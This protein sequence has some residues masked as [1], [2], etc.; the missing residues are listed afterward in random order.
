MV[1]P[2]AYSP[3]IASEDR[4]ALVTAM[5]HG[6]FFGNAPAYGGGD[7]ARAQGMRAEVGWP[8]PDGRGAAFYDAIDVCVGEPAVDD[9]VPVDRPEHRPFGGGDVEPG[10]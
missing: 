10:A 2:E 9:G 8:Q 1:V 4:D 5:G 7:P 6:A 3:D